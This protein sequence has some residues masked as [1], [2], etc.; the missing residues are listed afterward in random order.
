M[1]K[2]G[3]LYREIAGRPLGIWFFIF[4]FPGAFILGGGHLLL[5]WMSDSL[6]ARAARHWVIHSGA[7]D[8][9]TLLWGKQSVSGA[10][11][12]YN[13]QAGGGHFR[14]AAVMFGAESPADA[15]EMVE[16][17]RVGDPVE[18]YVDPG[19]P[20]QSVLEPR[21]GSASWLLPAL[22]AALLSVGIAIGVFIEKHSRPDPQRPA[23]KENYRSTPTPAPNR[24]SVPSASTIKKPLWKRWSP[25][26]V[27]APNEPYVLISSLL[28]TF[29]LG[30]L[31]IKTLDRDHRE[32]ELGTRLIA[33]SGELVSGD[34]NWQEQIFGNVPVAT[35]M[36]MRSN[37]L[38]VQ[39]YRIDVTYRYVVDGKEYTGTRISTVDRAFANEA[40]ARAQLDEIR[41]TTPLIV[42]YDSESPAYSLLD[43]HYDRNITSPLFWT[44][45]VLFVIFFLIALREALRLSPIALVWLQ[46]IAPLG[47]ILAA[48]LI[49]M[50]LAILA[51][52]QPV[53]SRLLPVEGYLVEMHRDD[54][55]LGRVRI[56]SLYRPPG[57]SESV[58]G[59]EW[60]LGLKFVWTESM[61]DDLRG[62]EGDGLRTFWLDPSTP[63][64]VVMSREV[65]TFLNRTGRLV[66]ALLAI[67]FGA[68]WFDRRRRARVS[69]QPKPTPVLPRRRL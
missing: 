61:F 49:V 42:F 8:A 22:G 27:N 2:Q 19:D 62:R 15:V 29:M 37:Q 44:S 13:Y 46:R 43:R 31:V 28:F 17:Y 55:L 60:R 1:K 24:K 38:V 66:C 16:R 39:N 20:T 26:R 23:S 40:D 58:R 67:V 56:D 51:W 11:I 57:E 59:G 48:P 14:S 7:I 30:V 9:S 3:F 36:S 68:I 65:G 35:T 45:A 54:G 32:A 52:Y 69:T 34:V 47:F 64:R 6:H 33:T 25:F 12:V 41:A 5:G 50:E 4:V 21:M 18:V 53:L 10:R 63:E